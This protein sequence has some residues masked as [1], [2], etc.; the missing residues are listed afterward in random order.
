M[1]I[2]DIK[3]LLTPLMLAIIAMLFFIAGT[4]VGTLDIMIDC[5]T[6]NYFQVLDSRYVC[7]GVYN[8]A[9]HN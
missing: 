8:E 1:N 2:Q 5:D 6:A 3:E 7:H 4:C 9:I